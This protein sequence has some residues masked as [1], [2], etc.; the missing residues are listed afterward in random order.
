MLC[1]DSGTCRSPVGTGLGKAAYKLR[2]NRD[3]RTVLAVCFPGHVCFDVC[4]SCVY[5]LFGT[6][7]P[8]ETV[9]IATCT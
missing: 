6:W 7:I 2:A 3:M 9:V 8:F 5:S 1:V 4:I